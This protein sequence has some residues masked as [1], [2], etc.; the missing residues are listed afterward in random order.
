MHANVLFTYDARA[1]MR[2]VNEPWP[3]DRD[4]A[5]QFF[6]DR[7]IDAKVVCRLRNDI[8]DIVAGQLWHMLIWK[9]YPSK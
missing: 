1:R 9:H 2:S 4:A 7:A 8:G 3:G 6:L 5:P